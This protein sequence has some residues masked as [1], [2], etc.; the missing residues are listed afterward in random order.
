MLQALLELLLGGAT[1]GIVG[2]VGGLFRAWLDV[3][4]TRDRQEHEYKLRQLDASLEAAQQRH[5]IQMAAAGRQRAQTE[6]MI[7]RDVGEL[8]AFTTSLRESEQRYGGWVD[9]WRGAMRPGIT[10]YVLLALTLWTALFWSEFGGL[11]AFTPDEG[12]SML[13][14]LINAWVFL[15]TGAVGW[16]FAIRPS[17]PQVS[18]K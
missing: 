13:R 10:T 7:A 15:S 5:E 18:R 14:Q 2:V 12:R 16:W 4:A 8:N 1:G 3:R 11:Q 17:Q 9:Q 6:A